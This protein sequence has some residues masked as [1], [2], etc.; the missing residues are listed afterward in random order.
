MLQRMTFDRVMKFGG[1]ALADGPGVERVCALV[2]EQGGPRPVLVVSAH[3]GVTE[4]LDTVARS[5]AEGILEG[6]RVR[7][8]HRTIL[9]QLALDS[10]LLD[11]HFS[12]FFSLLDGVQQRRRLA[13]EE[14]D[15]ALSFGERMSA[16]IVAHALRARGVLA[17]PVDAFD[18][19]LTSDSSFGN[20]L[21]L[22]DSLGEVRAG[23]PVVTGFLAK[24][25]HGN[26]T[27]LGRNGSDLTAALVAEAVG[28]SELQLWKTVGGLMTADPKLVPDAR[29][30]ERL[31][32]AEAAEYAFHGAEV[33]H[34]AALAPARRAGIAVRLLDVNRPDAAGTRLDPLTRDHGPCGIAARKRVVRV[35]LPLGPESDRPARLAEAF[36]AFARQRVETG[37]L[38]HTGEHLSLLAAPGPTL[39]AALAELGRKARAETDLALVA[40]IGRHTG[41]GALAD[42]AVR[43]LLE[44]GIEPIESHVGARDLS[45]AFLVRAADL[46]RAA[47]AL[48]GALLGRASAGMAARGG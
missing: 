8:R 10:E 29:V 33:L 40:L 45:Q 20:A 13:L 44:A 26:L 24:D 11:R 5:A 42:Q 39:D 17:T 27:T 12:E 22:G 15:M 21:P 16:R 19:G 28:A 6:D 1:A 31:G 14:R 9:R 32:F 36:N 35:L 41:D 47:R 18:L 2:R 38:R 3:Q 4:M 23:V 43:V 46:E 25:R 7:I 48:H 37:P 30:I 34:G